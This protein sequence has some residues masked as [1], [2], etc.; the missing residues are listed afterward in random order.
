MAI[1]VVLLF[2]LFLFLLLLSVQGALW[3]M[4]DQAA[5][6]AATAGARAAATGNPSW[7]TVAA[8]VPARYLGDMQ[9]VEVPGAPNT[10]TVKVTGVAPQI[11]P[12][13]VVVSSTSSFPSGNGIAGA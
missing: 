6:D 11:L 3:Y 8:D 5:T 2:P 13:H 9:A 7:A 4:A 1:E 10:I 12:F